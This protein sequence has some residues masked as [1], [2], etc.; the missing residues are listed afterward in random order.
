LSA[1]VQAP[2]RDAAIEKVQEMPDE[3]TLAD[4]IPVFKEVEE[5]D[6][7]TEIEENGFKEDPQKY[8]RLDT[9]EAETVEDREERL[10]RGE[11]EQ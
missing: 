7:V 4:V 5:V 8:L 9:M 10:A 2:N 6:T 3:E 11:S 1:E